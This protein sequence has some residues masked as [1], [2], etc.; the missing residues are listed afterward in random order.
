MTS[1]LT[2]RPLLQMPFYRGHYA[3]ILEDIL[4][5]GSFQLLQTPQPIRGTARIHLSVSPRRLNATQ[6]A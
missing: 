4:P 6:S 5:S 2:L 1:S 3:A